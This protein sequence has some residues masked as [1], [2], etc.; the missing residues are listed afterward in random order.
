MNRY[1]I[2][3]RVGCIA[4]IDTTIQAPSPGLHR[5]DPHV[6]WYRRGVVIDG[7]IFGW[8]HSHWRVP[9][10]RVKQAQRVCDLLNS[11]N[12]NRKVML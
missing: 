8:S 1:Q 12:P 5:D 10:Y 9:K 3:E 11:L 6:V 2:D 7:K 4:V